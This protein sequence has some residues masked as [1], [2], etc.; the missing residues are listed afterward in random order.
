MKTQSSFLIAAP[1]SGSG[2]TTVSLGLMRALRNRGRSVQPFKCGPDYIDTKFHERACG[3][4]SVNLDRFLSTDSHIKGLYHRYFQESGVAVVEGVMGLFDGYD[5]SQGSSAEIAALLDLPVVLVVNAK[6]TAYSVAPLL[7]GFRHFSDSIRIAGVIFNFV[8]SANHY[9]LLEAA[10]REVGIPCLG[11]L[12]KDS[13]IS[14]P[15]RHLGLNTESIQRS[16]ELMERATALVEKHIDIDRLL[17]LTETDVSKRFFPPSATPGEAV[18]AVARDEAF[19]FMYTANLD[20]MEQSARLV[21]FSPIHDQTLPRAD[22]LYFPGGYP[23]AHLE[24]LSRNGPM[25]RQI[26]RFAENGGKIWAECGGMMYLCKSIRDS[27][28]NSYPMVGIFPHRASV[29]SMKLTLGYRQFEWAGVS[30]RGHEFHYSELEEPVRSCTEILD[31]KGRPV[32]TALL[33]CR[34][35][36]AGY[37]HVYWADSGNLFKLFDQ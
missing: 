8:G 31:A 21:T 30:C 35:V 6:A 20:W 12:P 23:E 2:K 34:N 4:P 37:T 36:L 10:A 26:R 22:L 17:K 27:H 18:I 3:R 1:H 33:R 28:G 15:S 14:I 5:K 11:Y 19:E 16:D 29:R 13:G 25:R 32:D 7:Y 9:A 24:E